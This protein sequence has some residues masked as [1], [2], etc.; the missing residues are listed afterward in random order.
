[1][2]ALNRSPW[3]ETN[4]WISMTSTTDRE[5]TSMIEISCPGSL[6][7]P[8]APLRYVWLR[9]SQEPATLVVDRQLVRL[10]DQAGPRPDVLAAAV[11]KEVERLVDDVGHSQ[12]NG[13]L[14]PIA[15]PSARRGVGLRIIH[16]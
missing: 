4:G 6:P 15:C 13:P 14:F 3:G 8:Q 1:V 2:A 16:T 12:H 7:V 10:G 11:V 9:K 5:S